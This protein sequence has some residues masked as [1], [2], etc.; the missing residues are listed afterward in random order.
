MKQILLSIGILLIAMN[1]KAEEC[2][3]LVLSF[4][5]EESAYDMVAHIAV[6]SNKA[7][8]IIGKFI[9]DGE[10]LLKECPKVYSL[11][12][13]YTLK[14]KL[15]LAR[16]NRESCRVF[17]QSQVGSYARSHPEEIVVY[18]WGTIRQIR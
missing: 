18:K 15:A 6:A 3:V 12:R 11:D 16:K 10:R 8:E 2:R 4:E 9:D 17:T 13:Q 14:R 1:I 5:K 7:Y